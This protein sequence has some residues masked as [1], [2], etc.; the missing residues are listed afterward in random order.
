MSDT[1]RTNRLLIRRSTV[2][3]D[4]AKLIDH[5]CEL[6]RELA[7]CRKDA[8]RYRWLRDETIQDAR[9]KPLGIAIAILSE[10]LNTSGYRDITAWGVAWEEN[11]DE[12]IDAAIA[13]EKK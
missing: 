10:K 11:A 6:E 1:P 5:A 9:D 12:A 8:E 3:Q 13:K 4:R 2:S 7:E